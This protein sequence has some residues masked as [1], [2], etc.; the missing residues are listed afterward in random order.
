MK[1]T[2]VIPILMII[3]AILSR[4]VTVS[5]AD[6]WFTVEKTKKPRSGDR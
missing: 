1:D 2:I 5:A 6:S 3:T 4:P